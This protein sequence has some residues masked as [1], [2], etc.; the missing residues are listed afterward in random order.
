[1]SVR[2]AAEDPTRAAFLDQLCTALQFLG[3]LQ[4]E[5]VRLL[6]VQEP[7]GAD[8]ALEAKEFL[9]GPD[10]PYAA[11]IRPLLEVDRVTVGGLRV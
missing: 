5:Q 1:M 3:K 2:R 11:Y 7:I 9:V 4:G 10:G 6:T 8:E